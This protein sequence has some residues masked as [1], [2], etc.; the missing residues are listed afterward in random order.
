MKKYVVLFIGVVLVA[1][2]I[3]CVIFMGDHELDLNRERH[4]E[5]HQQ[6]SGVE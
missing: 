4:T 6:S 2:I 5:P 1:F 3:S